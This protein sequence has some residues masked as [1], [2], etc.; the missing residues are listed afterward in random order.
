MDKAKLIMFTVL[1]SSPLAVHSQAP[2]KFDKLLIISPH[3]AAIKEEILPRFKAFYQKQFRRELQVDW[4]DHGGAINDQ[5]YL[6]SRFESSKF[7]T[8]GVDIFWGG[9]EPIF[10][11]LEDLGLLEQPLKGD[12]WKK[13]SSP[14][15]FGQKNRNWQTASISTFG[16]LLNHKIFTLQKIPPPQTWQDLAK[17]FYKNLTVIADPRYS[18]SSATMMMGFLN[19]FGWEKAWALI[20]AVYANALYFSASSSEPAHAI[21]SGNAAIAM[22]IDYFANETLAQI[23]SKSLQFILPTDFTILTQD[24]IAILKGAPNPFAARK[25]VDFILSEA[26]QK[27]LSLQ[28]GEPGGPKNSYIGRTPI[29]AHL[30]GKKTLQLSR[31]AHP[32][33]LHNPKEQLVLCDIIG[34]LLID[35]KKLL[36]NAWET[37]SAYENPKLT[38]PIVSKK[39]FFY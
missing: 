26:G 11:S 34:R 2:S 22:V 6:K 38:R 10:D 8:S 28:V 17:P 24:P 29:L 15:I 7:Q 21:S 32:L 37:T 30:A 3:R 23:N 18:S 31:K 14:L 4:I 19:A 35:Q 33:N 16:L 39:E 36:N 1:C 5:N 27:I 9:N 20:A 12:S 13:P 25:F